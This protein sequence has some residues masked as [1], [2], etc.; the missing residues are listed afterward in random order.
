MDDLCLCY[1][2]LAL[3]IFSYVLLK[4]DYQV[5]FLGK[6]AVQLIYNRSHVLSS[7]NNSNFL[8]FNIPAFHIRKMKQA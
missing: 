1:S 4:F 6:K 5:D 7:L 2:C 8:S 3:D